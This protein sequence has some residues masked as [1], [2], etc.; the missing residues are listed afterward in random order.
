[1]ENYSL[2]SGINGN[3]D[4]YSKVNKPVYD[5]TEN[6]KRSVSRY[7]SE[8]KYLYWRDDT[9][10]NHYGIF[11]AMNYTSTIIKKLP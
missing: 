3:Q 2:Q 8:E 11:E 1:M 10:W 5:L 6:M 9:H 4:S 7:L